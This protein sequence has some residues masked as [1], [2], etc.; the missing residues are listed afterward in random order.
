M[1]TC[2]TE[3]RSSLPYRDLSG[4]TPTTVQRQTSSSRRRQSR[5]WRQQEVVPVLLRLWCQWGLPEIK[6]SQR[7]PVTYSSD[8]RL[9]FC[10][11]STRYGSAS[12]TAASLFQFDYD[13]VCFGDQQL[14]RPHFVIQQGQIGE[15][16]NGKAA[17]QIQRSTHLRNISLSVTVIHSWNLHYWCSTALTNIFHP[18][19]GDRYCSL[20]MWIHF[21]RLRSDGSPHCGTDGSSSLWL[22]PGRL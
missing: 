21:L 1:A 13:K 14:V 8:D 16:H 11:K 22:L 9:T 17:E 4:S 20:P 12:P 7:R 3:T 18:C 10:A 19:Q 6:D 5:Q 2:S 15:Q